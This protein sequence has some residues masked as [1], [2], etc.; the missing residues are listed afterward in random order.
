MLIMLKLTKT[1]GPMITIITNMLQDLIIFIVLWSVTILMVS[2]FGIIVIG[3][4]T[5]FDS[6]YKAIIVVFEAGLG[7]WALKIYNDTEL[8]AEFG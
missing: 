8:G 2:S 3:E 7:A 4:I 5:A 6:L 1:F